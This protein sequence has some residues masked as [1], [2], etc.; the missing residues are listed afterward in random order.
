[1][2]KNISSRIIIT[3]SCIVLA[4]ILLFALI[5]YGIFTKF[6]TSTD[7]SIMTLSAKNVADTVLGY[8]FLVEEATGNHNCSPEDVI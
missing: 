4:G 3:F 6:S 7:S 1:M 8:T 5:T 2:F